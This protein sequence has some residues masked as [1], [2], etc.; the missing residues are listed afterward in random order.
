MAERTGAEAPP[1][2]PSSSCS[3]DFPSSSV[4]SLDAGFLNTGHPTHLFKI[5]MD[6]DRWT[7][8]DESP[9]TGIVENAVSCYTKHCVCF[10]HP[11]PQE[12]YA[13]FYPDPEVNERH[14][15]WYYA[16]AGPMFR[17]DESVEHVPRRLADLLN[18]M[19]FD[20]HRAQG[21]EL[22]SHHNPLSY[23]RV[24]KVPSECIV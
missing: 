14:V 4:S 12:F 24:R 19:F 23:F 2:S 18:N 11:G 1:P 15:C 5:V 10:G 7:E 17:D 16:L 6:F 8:L 20:W 9:V 3:S 13:G 22:P 21:A